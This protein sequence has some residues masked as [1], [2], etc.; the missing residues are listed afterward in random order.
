MKPNMKNRVGGDVQC[1]I[2]AHRLGYAEGRY[3]GLREAQ[4]LFAAETGGREVLDGEAYSRYKLGLADLANRAHNDVL[5]VLEH[6]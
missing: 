4:I 2:E 6:D 3:E 1:V 5:R